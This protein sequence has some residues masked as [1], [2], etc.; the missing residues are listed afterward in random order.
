MDGVKLSRRVK[1]RLFFFKGAV[2]AIKLIANGRAPELRRE[3]TAA[4]MKK[5]LYFVMY[6]NAGLRFV[7]E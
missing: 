4:H 7:A 3:A 5:N 1:L 6:F 2:T